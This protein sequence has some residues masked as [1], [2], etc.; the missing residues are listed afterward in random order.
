MRALEVQYIVL[1][2]A[3]PLETGHEQAASQSRELATQ[4]A[5]FLPA[6]NQADGQCEVTCNTEEVDTAS[7][8]ATSEPKTCVGTLKVEALFPEW[9]S[10][11]FTSVT[12]DCLLVYLQKWVVLA[13]VL[14]WQQHVWA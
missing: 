6:F 7:F 12:S 13:G 3:V 5:Y 8:S 14:H 1:I 11:L 4:A 9:H 10:V 2:G